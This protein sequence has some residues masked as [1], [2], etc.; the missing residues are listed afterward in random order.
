M[1][2]LYVS[3]IPSLI[4]VFVISKWLKKLNNSAKSLI[5]LPVLYGERRKGRKGK[6][7]RR[8]KIRNGKRKNMKN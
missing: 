2:K 5:I 4:G 7:K 6:R 1:M 8:R 3:K